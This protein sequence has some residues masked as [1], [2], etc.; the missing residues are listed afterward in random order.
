MDYVPLPSFLRPSSK[1]F[2]HTIHPPLSSVHA[3]LN[4]FHV[5]ASE[6]SRYLET[7]H[8]CSHLTSSIR[9]CLL[10]DSA[11]P[12]A[13]LLGVEYMITPDIYETLPQDE[14]RLWHS[15]VYEVKSGV[16]VMPRPNGV[17]E[18]AW[19]AGEDEAMKGIV[20]LYGKVYH[21]W[22]VDRGDE[23][24]LGEPQ[25]MTSLTEEGAKRVE[26]LEERLQ[27]RDR[28]EGVDT[29]KKKERRIGIKE[30][31]IHPDADWTWKKGT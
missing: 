3:H 10:Y 19:E 22:Q 27:D 15:H 12:S 21:L 9:Q 23:V 14:R 20:E 4:A 18:T 6:P 5:Y 17:P 11:S 24:P 7:H 30:P 28:R 26:G 16:L 8:Y 2:A 1:P 25:L 29:G 31:E 13:R